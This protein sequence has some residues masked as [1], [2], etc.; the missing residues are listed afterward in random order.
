[1]QDLT[2]KNL[3][4]SDVQF[5]NEVLDLI[6]DYYKFYKYSYVFRYFLFY[7]VNDNFLD[8]NFSYLYTQINQILDLL[9]FDRIPNILNI[10]DELD[11]KNKF[12]EIKDQIFFLT[13]SIK[14]YKNNIIEEIEKNIFGK[15]DYKLLEEPIDS[16]NW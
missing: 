4:I 9:E 5:L 13:K 7:D 6:K 12:I 16:F 2:K 11:F 8:Y 10:S 1:M 14:I 3:L 15:I